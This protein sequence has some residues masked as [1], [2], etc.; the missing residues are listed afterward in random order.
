M[1]ILKGVFNFLRI[2]SVCLRTYVDRARLIVEL[3]KLRHPQSALLLM[4]SPS[5]GTDI[6]VCEFGTDSPQVENRG[7]HF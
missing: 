1:F 4:N 2:I 5:L 3:N 7:F 6:S